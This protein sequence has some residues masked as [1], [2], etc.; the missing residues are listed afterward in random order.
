MAG[1]VISFSGDG[2]RP[3]D[4]ALP[5]S[6]FTWN[7][8][9][10]HEGH[11]HPGT[12]QT[13]V[14]SGTFTIPTTGHDF[15]GNTRYRIT[16]TVT[17]SDGLTTTTV[18]HRLA[19]EGQPQLHH[20]PGGPHALPRRHRQGDAVRLRH[21]DRL[22]PHDRGP[23]PELGRHRPTHSLRGRTGAPSST[24]S[25]CPARPQLH[26]PTAR[27]SLPATPT[28]VQVASRVAADP[29]D[30]VATARQAQTA[31]NLNVVVVGGTTPPRTIVS[32]TD[33]AG[34]AYQIAAPTTYGRRSARRS[35]TPTTSPPAPTRSA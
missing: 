32:V 10:L 2:N 30:H 21:A 20:G 31:G 4:G 1:D 16:L 28:F 17:D 19:A 14:K 26:A 23:R 15:S 7:I 27:T 13:G 6:A 33:S 24:R 8:D 11:V 12:P 35:T 18:G 3:E 29:R 9:F 5:A 34:N 22:Q 25:S